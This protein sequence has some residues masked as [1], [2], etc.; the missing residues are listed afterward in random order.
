MQRHAFHDLRFVSS[1]C[2]ITG[3]ILAYLATIAMDQD[4][5]TLTHGTTTAVKCIRNFDKSC[6]SRCESTTWTRWRSLAYIT[7]V[8]PNEYKVNFPKFYVLIFANLLRVQYWLT[9]IKSTL[10]KKE[11]CK[12]VISRQQ[13]KLYSFGNSNLHIFLVKTNWNIE[14]AFNLYSVI[15]LSWITF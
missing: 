11:N 3:K 8:L 9:V 13:R 6:N 10:R 15:S 12:K 1:V 4:F 5:S 2:E 7:R 14:S